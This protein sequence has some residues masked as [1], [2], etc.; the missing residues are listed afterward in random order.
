MY[1]GVLLSA[2]PSAAADST[3]GN[4][5]FGWCSEKN[6][7]LEGLCTGYIRGVV[8]V[9]LAIEL[10]AFCFPAHRITIKQTTDLVVQYLNA[11]PEGRQLPAP[12]II[13]AAIAQSFP[14]HN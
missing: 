3:T 2:L 14:C 10:K 5:L 9:E 7:Y 1:V 8:D 6:I 4:Q 11:N 12:E 13:A